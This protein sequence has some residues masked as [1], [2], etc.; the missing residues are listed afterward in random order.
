MRYI[1][2]SDQATKTLIQNV[3]ATIT[4]PTPPRLIPIVQDEEGRT[5]PI[6]VAAEF[7]DEQ[8]RTEFPQL[9]TWDELEDRT[10]TGIAIIMA[11]Y[12]AWQFPQ[13]YR[14]NLEDTYADII[15]NHPEAVGQGNKHPAAPPQEVNPGYVLTSTTTENVTASYAS[16]MEGTVEGE[17]LTPWEDLPDTEKARLVQACQKALLTDPADEIT[18]VLDTSINWKEYAR[19]EPED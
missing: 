18:R 2:E 3:I 4:K 15:S 5:T 17:Y 13:H 8:L 9:L 1:I 16:I 14:M 6:H 10:Q 11:G 12:I 19:E 7:Y